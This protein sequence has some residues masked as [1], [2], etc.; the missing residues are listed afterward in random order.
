MIKKDQESFSIKNLLE[1]NFSFSFLDYPKLELSD[2]AEIKVYD[3]YINLISNFY[4]QSSSKSLKKYGILK[5]ITGSFIQNLVKLIGEK[6]SDSLIQVNL[7]SKNTWYDVY[8]IILN[9]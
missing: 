9:A 5:D 2:F 4:T 8:L 7:L 3:F 1:A 6:T